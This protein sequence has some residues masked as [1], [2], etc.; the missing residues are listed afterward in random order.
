MRQSRISLRKIKRLQ[1]VLGVLFIVAM[2]FGSAPA[3]LAGDTLSEVRTLLQNNYV[4]PVSDSVLSAGSIP[5][6]LERLGDPHTIFFTQQ[7]FQAFLGSLE[8]IQFAGLGINIDM[9]S[10]GVKVTSVFPGS[11]AENAGLKQGDI[12]IKAGQDSLA[13]ITAEKAVSILRG[14]AGTFILLTV[15]RGASLLTLNVERKLIEI[16]T[17]SGN[18][19]DGGL[20]YVNI[21]SFGTDT[22]AALG[23]ILG[24]LRQQS[25]KG[26]IIDLRNNP[27]GYLSSVVDLASYFIGPN[28]VVQVRER[29]G[30]V[31][32][33][34]SP[35]HGFTLTEP[36]I[37]LT[38]DYTASA[39]EILSAAVKDYKKATILGITTYGKGT[40]QDM[41]NLSDGSVLKMTV[42]H[43][44]SPFG[45]AINK[46]GI[47]PDLTIENTD[48]EMAAR[49]LLKSQDGVANGA[50][51]QGFVQ[52]K[53]PQQ[54]FTV[55][56]ADVRKP[57][58]WSSYAEILTH[59]TVGEVVKGTALGWE[60]FASADFAKAFSFFYPD[61]QLVSTLKDV[62]L[63]KKFTVHFSG[64]PDWQTIN[65]STVELLNSYTGERV[66]IA[67]NPQ[68]LS[69]VQVIPQEKL[70][71]GTTYWLVM[72]PGIKGV[73]GLVSTTGYIAEALTAV[74]AQ[75]STR[76]IKSAKVMDLGRARLESGT[77][78]EAV[79]S[80]RERE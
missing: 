49:L 42:A 65:S 67:F 37:F 41:F 20:G 46:V 3:A 57:S 30:K 8:G 71:S 12:I 53:L 28:K 39:S 2:L 27:G 54:N 11:G 22:A 75:A 36:V 13:G 16:P 10:E 74:P 32:E 34:V 15:K 45:F 70:V 80:L 59:L 33:L 6:M 7:Q 4:D 1:Q 77:Y 40:V 5:E 79:R 47:S 17:V 43:F 72:H 66:P 78:G 64:Q 25:I 55:D 73:N 56:L 14:D 68:G 21:R 63:D 48:P 29:D 35:T 38:N 18:M 58:Y 61:Y 76:S 62:P 69:D 24:E 51:K 19:V 9:A 44:Y 52:I 31:E 50:N 23:K 60:N 26:W